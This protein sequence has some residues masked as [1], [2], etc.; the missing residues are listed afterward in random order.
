MPR[1]QYGASDD[2]NLLR[3]ALL[4]QDRSDPNSNAFSPGRTPSGIA[5][6]AYLGSI[7]RTFEQEREGGIIDEMDRRTSQN[8]EDARKRQSLLDDLEAGASMRNFQTRTGVRESGQPKAFTPDNF[9]PMAS[10][11]P[12]PEPEPIQPRTIRRFTS[13][14]TKPI[15]PD[16]AMS[17]RDR[18]KLDPRVLAEEARTKGAIAIANAKAASTPQ[19]QTPYSDERAFRN[20]QSIRDLT[21][22]VG[23]MT[24]GPG[25]MLSAIPGTDARDFAA[26]LGTL[27]ANIAFGELAA[28]REAS[29]TGGALGAVSEKEMALLEAALGALDAGQSPANL[30]KNLRQ[31]EESVNR[32]NAAR[33][34]GQEFDWVPGKG[35]VPRGGAR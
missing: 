26:D 2:Y 31:V 5:M 15:D 30:Q 9:K 1:R 7:P 27:K 11:G 35:L 4:E 16:A 25:S 32:W 20:L 28:M 12:T 22:R 6:N 10:H 3:L 34:G 8:M 24:A 21:G 14:G 13:E 19:Q 18:A 17:L 23:M 33:G 29:K